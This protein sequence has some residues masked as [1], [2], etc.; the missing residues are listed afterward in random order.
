[1][2]RTIL[3][4]ILVLMAA[5]VGWLTFDWYRARSS[6]EAFGAPFTAG[7]PEGRGDHRSG[8]PRPAIG[9]VL[10]L[11]P[12]PG[13]L[14]DHAVRARRLAEAARRRRQGHP[15]LFRH[16]SIPSATR[17]KRWTVMSATSR[18]A[19]PA[20]PATREGRGDG[21]G[22]QD[23]F[24]E[25]AAG[26][27][28]LHDGSHGSILLLDRKGGFFGTIAYGEDPDD[29]ARQA[30]APCRGRLSGRAHR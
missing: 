18:T 28:R 19:S 17:P 9:C 5:G 29:R 6:A 3:V 8:V 4:G 10:R 21:Q 22:L 30:Q 1:M 23:L 27:R 13:G 26:R 15:R 11:H 2:M 12:L 25:G 16:R 14:P 7:R 24:Q 20:S